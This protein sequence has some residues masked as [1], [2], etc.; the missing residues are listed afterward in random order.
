MN[1]LGVIMIIIL[2]IALILSLR[3][4]A[5]ITLEDTLTIRAGLGPIILQFLPKKRK[6]VDLRDFTYEKHQKRLEKERKKAAKKKA[7]LQKKTGAKALAKKAEKASQSAENVGDTEKLSTVIEIIEFV[8]SELSSVTSHIHTDIRMLRI[9]VVGEDAASIAKKYGVICAA[10]SLIIE[11]LNIKTKLRKMNTD[12]VSVE[13]D[14]IS[15][16]TTFNIDIQ[17]KISLFSLL[18]AGFKALGWFISQKSKQ[19]GK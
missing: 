14:F 2:I 13:A 9:R 19:I 3:L 12:V 15:E 8:T 1:A 4:K 16:K 18:K 10:S 5:Y 11:L 7:K 17:L 6:E